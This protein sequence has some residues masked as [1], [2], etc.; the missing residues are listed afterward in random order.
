[1][2]A[3]LA[4]ARV[5]ITV[6]L[7]ALGLAA[8]TSQAG[9]HS[10]PPSLVVHWESYDTNGDG[11]SWAWSLGGYQPVV[12]ADAPSKAARVLSRLDVGDDIQLNSSVIPSGRYRIVKEGGRAVPGDHDMAFNVGGRVLIGDIV[13]VGRARG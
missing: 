11:G 13:W 7:I 6:G 2:F 12:H 1:M 3:I 5:I 4:S 8:S 10:V 9:A